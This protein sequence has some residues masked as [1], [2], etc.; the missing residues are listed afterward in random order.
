MEAMYLKLSRQHL[1]E[2]TATT[3]VITAH[4]MILMEDQRR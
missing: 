3:D 1:P 4:A 2:R